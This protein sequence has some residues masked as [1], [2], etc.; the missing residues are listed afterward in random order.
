MISNNINDLPREWPQASQFKRSI[1]LEFSLYVSGIIL[2][3]MLVTGYVISNQYVKTVTKNVI[4]KLLVQARSYSRPA[5]KLIISTGEPDALLL[6][7]ICRKL[8]DDNSEVYWVG[9]ANKQNVFIAHTDLRQVIAS[10]QMK[11]IENCQTDTG[12]RYGETFCLSR[13][14]IYITVPI[15][16]DNILVGKLRVAS[17]AEPVD[18]ARRTSITTVASITILVL[19]VGLPITMIVL[20]R[21]LRPISMITDGLKKLDFEN[22]T[23]DIPIATKNEFGY[24]TETLQVMGAKLKVAQRDL[25]EKERIARELEIAHEIQA[26]ILPRKY[27]RTSNY[28]FAGAYRSAREVGGDYYDFIDIDKDH[29]GFLIADVSG[30]SLPGMLVMLLTR[31]IIVR[32]ARSIKQPA[33]LLTEVNRELL[34]SIKR[35]MFVTMFYGVLN[36]TTGCFIFASAGHNPLVRLNGQTG[37]SELIKTKGYPLGMIPPEPFDKRIETGRILLLKNDW[38]I[39]YTDGIN[40]AQNSDGEEFGMDRFVQ[41]LQSHRL[42]CPKELSL[43]TL[44]RLER[45]VDSAPQYDDITLVTMKWV[46]SRVDNILNE[47]MKELHA[48]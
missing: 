33:E 35:N 16:E 45:F 10:D 42:L 48:S 25:V 9:I 28:E 38:L 14:T 8:T 27:P 1:R 12:L 24:L 17:S 40:E 26:N 4:D 41:V 31:D 21:K 46:G 34:L 22:I 20:R 39:Q 13:D 7:N 11:P 30:K 47:P 15:E 23:L 18:A 43:Q 2:V 29:L 32:L 36:K 44:G 3:L 19:L 37:E 6:N 5:G